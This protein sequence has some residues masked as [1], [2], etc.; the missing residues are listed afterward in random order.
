M[1][2]ARQ[3]PSGM[4]E[5]GVRHPSLPG[6]RKYFTFDTEEQANGFGEQWTTMKLAGLPPPAELLKPVGPAHSLGHVIRLWANSGL[7][8]PSQFSVLGSLISEVGAVKL[9][10]AN[11]AW[12]SSY[13]QRLKVQNNL[14]PNSIRHRVQALGRAIDEFARTNPTMTIANPVRLLPKGYS[15]YTA[16]DQ[17]LVEASG[18]EVK[19]D[20]ERDR[21]LHPGEEERIIAALSGKQRDDRERG[22]MLIGGNALLCM[23]QLIVGSGLRLREAYRLQRGQIDLEAKVMRVQSSKQWRGKVVFRDVP[24]RPEVHRALS[25]YLSTRAMLPAAYLFPFMEEE[26]DMTLKKVTQR[27]SDRFRIAFQYADCMD[28]REHD[29]RHEAT[30]RWL[31]LRDATGNWMFRLEEVNRI[32]GWSANSTMAQRYASFRGSDLAQRMW[33]T[34]G[35]E[36]ATSAR[37]GGGA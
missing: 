14:A 25:S 26:P 34:A 22:L 21:R 27:L 7:A 4:W 10:D 16:L 9:A 12:L 20:V 32:M 28:L 30:C 17:K 18:K 15:T 3:K 36:S 33:A 23:F 5:I 8:A 6:G 2:K 11:Y 29:L 13:V 35:P 1:A 24:M 19:E 31:E 37:A